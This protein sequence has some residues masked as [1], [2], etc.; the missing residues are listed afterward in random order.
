[1]FPNNYMDVHYGFDN[2]IAFQESWTRK[3]MLETDIRM[4]NIA[5]ALFGKVG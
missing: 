1:M 3:I 2:Q 4:C 5:A